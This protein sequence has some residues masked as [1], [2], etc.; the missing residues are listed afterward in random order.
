MNEQADYSS[1]SSEVRQVRRHKLV[2]TIKEMI[3][4]AQIRRLIIYNESGETV[5]DLK[6]GEGITIALV[7][8]L[9]LPKV[10]A[11]VLI[12]PLLAGFKIQIVRRKAEQI[13]TEPASPPN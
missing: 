12:A 8:T 10:L 11:L 7:L 13:N 2:K 1:K 3:A 4:Q 5:L 9:V 6:F